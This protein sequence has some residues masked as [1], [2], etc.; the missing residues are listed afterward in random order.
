MFY[1]VPQFLVL[2]SLLHKGSSKESKRFEK[3]SIA[4]FMYNQAKKEADGLSIFI[5]VIGFVHFSFSACS[6]LFA[7]S[8][9]QLQS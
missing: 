2:V 9:G 5:S 3:C 1:A 7:G 8:S 4:I 6:F